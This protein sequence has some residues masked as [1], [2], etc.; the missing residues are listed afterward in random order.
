MGAVPSASFQAALLDAAVGL[1][2][3][4]REVVGSRDEAT[5]F[6]LNCAQEVHGRWVRD[7]L[8]AGSRINVNHN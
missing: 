5:D 4:E 3:V 6:C 7:V 8:L 1:G 2:G